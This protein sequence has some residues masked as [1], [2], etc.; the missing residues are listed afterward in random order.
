MVKFSIKNGFIFQIMASTIYT[1]LLKT[2]VFVTLSVLNLK[3]STKIPGFPLL[4][5][6][7]S[8]LKALVPYLAYIIITKIWPLNT[9]PLTYS[10]EKC[11]QGSTLTF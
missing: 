3:S 4:V 10:I 11:L 2:V 8:T 7:V 5:K 1:H 6:I 9:E